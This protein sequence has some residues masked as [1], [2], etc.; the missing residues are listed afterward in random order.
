MQEM[1]QGYEP[2]PHFHR[3]QSPYQPATQ[4]N[5]QNNSPNSNPEPQS[6]RFTNYNPVQPNQ[7]PI[8]NQQS[9]QQQW[10]EMQ[11]PMT[12]GTGLVCFKCNQQ[13]HRA[14]ECTVYPPSR[15]SQ[16]RG[17]GGYAS[18]YQRSNGPR[19]N[20]PYQ[21]NYNQAPMNLNN[22]QQ[23]QYFNSNQGQPPNQNNNQQSNQRQPPNQNHQQQQAN[24]NM[25]N[26]QSNQ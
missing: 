7:Q 5:F 26:A 1:P 2:Q 20:R 13:G 18:N 22:S 23:D 9:V 4:Q 14:R 16:Y 3:T 6:Q 17:G 15:N 11:M 12:P 10:N 25:M 8:N 21:Q 19:D 24:I